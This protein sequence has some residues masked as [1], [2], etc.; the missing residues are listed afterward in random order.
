MQYYSL[1]KTEWEGRELFVFLDLII[2][3]TICRAFACNQVRS[4]ITAQRFIEQTEAMLDILVKQY[5]GFFC[6]ENFYLRQEAPVI[7]V[8][9]LHQ[10][11]LLHKGMLMINFGKIGQAK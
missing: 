2:K 8:D 1:L 4:I 6:E 3:C 10:K 7:P 5:S 11:M 9:I